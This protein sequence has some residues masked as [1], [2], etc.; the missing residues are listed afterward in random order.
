[1]RFAAAVLAALC[2]ASAAAQQPTPALAGRVVEAETGAPLQAT[3]AAR[4]LGAPGEVRGAVADSL[5][6]YRL[7]LGSGRWAV[8]V[9]HAGFEAHRD[10]VELPRGA[11]L[12]V[13]LVAL[14]LGE[15]TV[16]GERAGTP[17]VAPERLEGQAIR[18]LPAFL[19]E[20]DVLKAVQ[21]L[22]GVRAGAE[23]T[24]GLYVRGGSP[25]QTLVLLDG[26]P[27]YNPT[28]L[29]GFVSTFNADVVGEAELV[30]GAV[31]ARYGGRL[32]SVLD[33]RT[34][35]ADRWHLGGQV[36]ALAATLTASAPLPGGGVLVSGRRSTVDLLLA[37]VLNRAADDA[38]KRG[39]ARVTPRARFAD[40]TAKAHWQAGRH[41]VEAAAFAGQDAF[42]FTSQ[43]PNEA[44]GTVD[45]ADGALDWGNRL[46]SARWTWTGERAR[47]ALRVA[48][49]DYGVDVEVGQTLGVGGTEEAGRA[50]YRS[51]IADLTAAADLAL[52]AGA[53]ELRAGGRLA[54]RV[55]TPGALSVVGEAAGGAALDTLL[56]TAETRALDG[57][58]YAEAG[59]RAGPARLDVGLAASVFAT[60]DHRHVGLE[61]RLAA[62]YALGRGV[63]LRAA[64]AR[65]WQP[66]HLLTT[67]AGIGLPADL[68]VP[69]DRVGP[70]AA[71]SVSAGVARRGPLTLS[72][73]GYWRRMSGLVAYREGASFATPFEDWQDLVV[74]GDGLAR[75]IEALVRH[76]GPRLTAA[77]GYTLARSDRQFD[78]LNGGAPFPYR[79]DRRHDVEA[80]A[81]VRLGRLDLSAVAVW[82]TGDAVTLP[83]ASYDAARYAPSVRAVA[84]GARS[85]EEATAYADRNGTRLPPTARLDLGATWH[86]RRGARAHALALHVYNATNR[87]NPFLTQLQTRSGPDGADRLQLVGVAVAPILPSLSYR[88]SL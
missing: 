5:G 84:G 48:A 24:A 21:L 22:P 66:L 46:A 57:A 49:S 55:F 69:A 38:A 15:L 77:L 11:P 3:V 87:K 53:H 14:D 18:E 73:D 45:L 28:H 23:G 58:L 13:A 16:R 19:G 42:A 30:R 20:A 6:A 25:D 70:E 52:S 68:W 80:L 29:F 74:T 34:R 85:T 2:A 82:A 86:F 65:T 41:R 26:T 7:A 78:A 12:D 44:D 62:A 72:L 32:A 36:G 39:E 8:E 51:A 1:M 50:R 88:F 54:R 83:D 63:S 81:V 9:R 61:P 33:V 47:S 79:Y 27:V 56:G 43:D 10:T 40:V 4:P 60:A 76:D 59:L 31:P 71:W 35:D 75:G 64:V 17:A 67:G 37:P